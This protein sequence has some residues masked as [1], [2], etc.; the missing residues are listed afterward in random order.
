MTRKSKITFQLY[1]KRICQLLD[2][3][4]EVIVTDDINIYMPAINKDESHKTNY[5]KQQNNLMTVFKDKLIITGSW[6]LNNKLSLFTNNY[7][8]QLYILCMN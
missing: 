5:R 1:V 8:S 7:K 4:Q 2:D 3:N 6:L